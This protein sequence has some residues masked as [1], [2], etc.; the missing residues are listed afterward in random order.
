[1]PAKPLPWMTTVTAPHTPKVSPS[2][3]TSVPSAPT[4]ATPAQ[5][6]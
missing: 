4:T 1:M 5:G 2:Y 6:P 3:G